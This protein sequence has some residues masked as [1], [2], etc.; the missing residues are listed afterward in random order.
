MSSNLVI[1]ESS[2]WANRKCLLLCCLVATANM[3]YGFDSSAVGA[4]QAMPGFLKVFGYEDPKSPIGYGIDV[5]RRLCR[6][7]L[8]L[9]WGSEHISAID[10]VSCDPGLFY[11]IPCR[12]FLQFILRTKRGTVAGLCFECCCCSY[13]DSYY[14]ERGALSWTAST[15][16]RKWISCDILQCVHGRSLTST[17]S[18]C[19]GRSF[20]LL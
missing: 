3:Q 14:A 5:R 6:G 2:L 16:S 9:T 1:P 20:R 10:H 17:S 18:R 12:G 15:W 7:I 13:S 8:V 19:Y 11:L 4:L